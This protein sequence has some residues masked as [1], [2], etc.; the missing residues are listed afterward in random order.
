MS[1]ASHVHCTL[2][3]VLLAVRRHLCDKT[4]SS[5]GAAT[6]EIK[7]DAL[8]I[9]GII[10]C[11]EVVVFIVQSSNISADENACLVC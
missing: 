6:F 1:C 3:L 2:P 7:W 5:F 4:V 10:S 11:S 8:C 9:V